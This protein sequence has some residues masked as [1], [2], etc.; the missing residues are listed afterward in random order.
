MDATHKTVYLDD[1][2][3]GQNL[4][5][6]KFLDNK[7]SGEYHNTHYIGEGPLF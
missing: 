5:R 3:L 7:L 2:E 6:K 4:F 1:I